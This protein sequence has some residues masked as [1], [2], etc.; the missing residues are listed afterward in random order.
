MQDSQEKVETSRLQITLSFRKINYINNIKQ[1]F[2]SAYAYEHH[3]L[4]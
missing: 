2:G 3:L 4:H 1:E